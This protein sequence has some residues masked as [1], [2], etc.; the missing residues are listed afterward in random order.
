MAEISLLLRM[1]LC[2]LNIVKY[3]RTHCDMGFKRRI[4]PASKAFQDVSRSNDTASDQ[5]YIMAGLMAV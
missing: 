5:R 3:L 2:T 4:A 1:E